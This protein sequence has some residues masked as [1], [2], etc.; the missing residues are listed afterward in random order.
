M[1]VHGTGL[2]LRMHLLEITMPDQVACPRLHTLVE[3]FSCLVQGDT[4]VTPAG[5]ANSMGAV[6]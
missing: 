1:G 2:R 5:V 4:G 3:H 6:K